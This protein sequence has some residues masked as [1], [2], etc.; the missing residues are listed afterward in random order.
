MIVRMKGVPYMTLEWKNA[1]RKKE[2]TRQE[3]CKKPYWGKPGINENMGEYRYKTSP[4]SNK[5]VMEQKSWWPETNPK[6]LYNV[7]KPFLH[8]MSKKCENTLLTLDI[9]GVIGQDQ[10]EIVEHFAKYFS[11]VANDIS[12]T[13]LLGMSED[14]LNYHESVYTI[15]KSC[16]RRHLTI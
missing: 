13:R 15:T 16:N 9:D 3:K 2:E 7:L 11:S 14:Q 4:E 5:R 1:I 6:N 8:S 12:D 10:C